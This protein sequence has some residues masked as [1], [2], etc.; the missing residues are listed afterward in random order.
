MSSNPR[1][2]VALG[3][4]DIVGARRSQLSGRAIN[5]TSIAFSEQLLAY[6]RFKKIETLAI[7]S[8]GRKDTLIDGHTTLE[9]MPKSTLGRGGIGFH[10]SMV[11]YGL[12]L[13][14]RARRF[15]ASYALID[16]GTT[17][18]F[19]LIPFRFLGIPVAVNLHNVLWP[20]GFPPRY[21]IQRVIRTLNR[22]FFGH[23]AAGAIG[24]SPECEHQLLAESRDRIPFFQ[25]RCQFKPEGFLVSQAY[26][27]GT[28]R[29]VFAGRIEENK[30]VFDIVRMAKSLR[31]ISPTPVAFDICGDGPALSQLREAIEENDL[32]D[33]VVAHGRQER[34]ALLAIYSA[35]HAAGLRRSR[36]VGASGDHQ[37]GRERIRCH[38]S[39]D[40]RRG[41]RSGRHLCHSDLD[42]HRGQYTT[43][44]NQGCLS[45]GRTAIFRSITELSGG[46]RS[47]ALVTFQDQAA[48]QLRS[49]V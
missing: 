48:R 41:D 16:S 43:R 2:F 15:G 34:S 36:R 13:A 8:H 10:L 22:L 3:P 45:A 11:L 20:C 39:G 9:N 12:R 26:R 40:D 46:R 23:A 44:Q 14:I 7:S 33:T 38:R 21:A 1:L 19:A 4:G 32:T 30:G 5:E 27:S 17:H 47:P 31:E 37:S 29:I 24:V 28:F 42:A 6:C 35:S 49:S 18:Y 25:Y